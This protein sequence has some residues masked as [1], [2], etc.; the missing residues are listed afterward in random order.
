V[1]P[2]SDYQLYDHDF[3]GV[4]W[5]FHTVDAAIRFRVTVK[6]SPHF[7]AGNLEPVRSR[8]LLTVQ[9]V[10]LKFFD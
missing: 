4:D 2:L 9:R 7:K 10:A 3:V 1:L 8:Q 5:R 6:A